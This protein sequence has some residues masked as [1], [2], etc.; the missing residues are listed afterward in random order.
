MG[1]RE[2]KGIFLIDVRGRGRKRQ[3]GRAPQPIF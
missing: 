3:N 1:V 2:N